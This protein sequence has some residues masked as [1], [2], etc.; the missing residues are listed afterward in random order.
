MLSC[1]RIPTILNHPWMQLLMMLRMS[2]W[3][4]RVLRRMLKKVVKRQE[5]EKDHIEGFAPE[6]KVDKLKLIEL[7]G[8]SESK[9]TSF[10]YYE[11]LM[12]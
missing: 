10:N 9:F 12:L 11:G 6:L 7:C 8:T 3:R 1:Q 2:S 5:R 4:Q